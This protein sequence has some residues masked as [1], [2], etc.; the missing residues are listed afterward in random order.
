[1]T[2]EQMMALYATWKR[3]HTLGPEMSNHL[4]NGGVYV[5][6]GGSNEGVIGRVMNKQR[7]HKMTKEDA[8]ALAAMLTAEQKEYVDRVVR[9][10]SKEM[11]ELGNEA[12]LRM[13]GIEKYKEDYYFPMKIWNGIRNA[14]SDAGAGGMDENRIAHQSFSKR[15]VN[16]ARNAL[17]I[18]NFTDTAVGHM[19]QMINYVTMAPAL[20]NLN[21]V[22]NYQVTTESG[23]KQNVETAFGESYGEEARK[24]LRQWMQD[25]NGGVTQDPRKTLRERALS[26]FKKN[27]VAGSLS[28]SLQQPLSYI[29]AA[30]MVNPKY[31]VKALS[32]KYWKGSYQ[33]MI[34]NSG[35][36]VIKDMGRFDMSMGQSAKDYLTPD[37]KTRKG[38]AALNWV[39]DK[40]T[41]LPEMMDRMTWT[42]MWS[43]VK[44]ETADRMPGIDQNSERFLYAVAERFNELMRRTQVYD[45]TLVKSS[46]MRSQNYAMKVLTSFMAEPTLT[47]NVLSDAVVNVK[48]KGGKLMLAKAGA[49][50]AASAVLQ[51]VI[52]GLMGTGRNPDDK[53]TWQENFL[54]RFGAALLSEANPVSMI[55]GYSDLI[56]VTPPGR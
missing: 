1:M 16:K 48:E 46:N 11:S 22:L 4:I 10:L 15:R 13:Y 25:L 8:K 19:V 52:K 7:A 37:K 50:F 31:L 5:D 33:E 42:R 26:T 12:S 24:Y 51:A 35:V 6:E 36:A 32:P 20:E 39:S 9:Y 2:L 17:V 21:R 28:V 56:E 23:T 27:A 47:L 45:S 49:A 30:V 34:R 43:A 14:K 44:A 53:K 55:P 54:N 41:V 18:G 38:R 3:E 40:T 29:R